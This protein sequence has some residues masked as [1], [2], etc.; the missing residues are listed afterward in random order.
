M[1]H[2]DWVATAVV[3]SI[4]SVL[5]LLLL[6]HL[7]DKLEDLHQRRRDQREIARECAEARARM[8]RENDR[9]HR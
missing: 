8:D 7:F 6:A 3:G 2:W 9:R 1:I 4:A 5:A